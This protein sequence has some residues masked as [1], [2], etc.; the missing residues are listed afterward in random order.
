MSIQFVPGQVAVGDPSPTGPTALSGTVKDVQTKVVKLSGANF[1]TGGTNNLVAV[2]PAD[3]S[4]IGVSHWVKTQLAGNGI[5][6]ATINLG[7]TSG[8]TQFVSAYN[9]FGTA[10][11]YTVVTPINSIVQSYQI[12]LG[13]DI[14]IYAGGT[15]TTGNPTSGEIY[16]IIEYVR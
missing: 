13:A 6:A 7:T 11:A 10:G 2:L 12:P 1:T 9:S 3:A 14:Q 5:T 4:I 16:L 8:G 15:S